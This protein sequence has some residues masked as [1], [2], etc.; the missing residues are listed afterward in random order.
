MLYEND[1]ILVKAFIGKVNGKLELWR[2]ALEVHD[3]Y[4][5][6]TEFMKCYFILVGSI[7]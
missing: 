4:L 7:F 6:R 3:F 5:S 1:I 2:K